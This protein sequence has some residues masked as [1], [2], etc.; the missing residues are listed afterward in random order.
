M[1]PLLKEIY[2]SILE[3]NASLVTEKTQAALDNGFATS[4]ILN[5]GMIA[6]MTEVGRLF[7][8][9]EYF[10]P[11]MLIGA[12]AMQA[13]LTVL[14]PYLVAD[15]V[16]PI[17]VVALGTVKGDLHDIGKNLVA[18]MVE[19]A[20]FEVNDLGTDVD[21]E[22]FVEAIRKG[23]SVIGLSAL[24]T[25]TIPMIEKTIMA[26]DVAGLRDQVKIM[27]GGAPVTAD[28]AQQIGADGYAPDASQAAKLAKSFV[29]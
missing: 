15:D 6:A 29:A 27:V 10:V 22:A 8:E 20:G 26:I 9:G 19:G 7:E 18:M 17:G 21:P 12:R 11:E 13:G 1:E 3:G 16:K 24:L 5:E 4:V 2:D 14:R 23:A 28:F 25:T